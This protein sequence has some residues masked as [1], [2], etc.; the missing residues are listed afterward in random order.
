MA[1][2]DVLTE[3]TGIGGYDQAKP[4]GN[5]T[6]RHV[7]TAETADEQ[8]VEVRDGA[9]KKIGTFKRPIDV[10]GNNRRSI[11]EQAR[12]AL[13]VN[14]TYIAR[15]T[16]T[17]AQTAAQVQALSRQVNGLLRVMLNQLDGTD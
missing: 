11:E 5:I 17:P 13:A 2:G 7:V 9:G 8:T 14:R 12:G 6:E 4:N 3:V 15:A 16:P 10:V 1:V